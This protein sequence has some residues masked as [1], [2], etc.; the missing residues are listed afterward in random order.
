MEIRLKRPV[1][2]PAGVRESL[3]E[4]NVAVDIADSLCESVSKSLQGKR[5]ESWTGV[6]GTVKQALEQAL[7]RI[8]T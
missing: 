5:M 3:V 2:N 8:L 4:K 1:V 6:K 7:T